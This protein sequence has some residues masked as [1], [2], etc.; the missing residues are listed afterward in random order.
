MAD[1]RFLKSEVKFQLLIVNSECR[2]IVTTNFTRHQW[3]KNHK[4]IVLTLKA[5]FI[6]IAKACSLSISIWRPTHDGHGI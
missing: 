6:P 3:V 5:I 4:T 2:K 1:V